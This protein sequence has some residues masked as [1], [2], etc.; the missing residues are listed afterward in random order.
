MIFY[1]E[2]LFKKFF[3]SEIPRVQKM[4]LLNQKMDKY[5]VVDI[6]LL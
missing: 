1:P 5:N 4:L 3:K 2:Y 6:Y